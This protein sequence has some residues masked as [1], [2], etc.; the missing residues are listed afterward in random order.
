MSLTQQLLLRALLAQFWQ[1][2]YERPLVGWGTWKHDRY[3][4]C[5]TWANRLEMSWAT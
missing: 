1:P 2:P 5:L 3:F 4:C